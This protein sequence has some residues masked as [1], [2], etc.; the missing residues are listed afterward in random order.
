MTSVVPVPGW[1][2]GSLMPPSLSCSVYAPVGSLIA[3]APDVVPVLVIA[4]IDDRQRSGQGQPRGHAERQVDLHERVLRAD[5]PVMV[6]QENTV[7]EIDLRRE[8]LADFLGPGQFAALRDE[9]VREI[10]GQDARGAD[11]LLGAGD[12]EAVGRAAGGEDRSRAE[13]EKDAGKH[14]APQDEGPCRT[15]VSLSPGPS[16]AGRCV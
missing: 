4:L 15:H 5:L 8:D 12:E 7:L 13:T 2:V 11:P 6:G 1:I 16:R 14:D 3:R 9:T 10:D